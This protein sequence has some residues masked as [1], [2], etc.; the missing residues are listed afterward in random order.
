MVPPAVIWPGP[1]LLGKSVMY[2][3]VAGAGTPMWSEAT[4]AP[5]R[6]PADAL[7]REGTHGAGHERRIRKTGVGHPAGGRVW[8]PSGPCA[9]EA[10]VV[11]ALKYPWTS[12]IRCTCPGEPA[13][14]GK[15]P[16]V[17]VPLS[18]SWTTALLPRGDVAGA[19]LMLLLAPDHEE[20]RSPG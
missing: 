8:K 4:A 7:S 18:A 16:R 6:H 10:G 17:P 5:C 15:M 9:P 20:V 2:P 1:M 3:L 12:R 19:K 13:T 11:S 14:S